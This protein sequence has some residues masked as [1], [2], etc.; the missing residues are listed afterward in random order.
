MD[1][2]RNKILQYRRLKRSIVGKRNPTVGSLVPNW[3]QDWW[4]QSGNTGAPP[5]HPDL[6][7]VKIGS[8]IYDSEQIVDRVLYANAD[9]AIKRWP[10]RTAPTVYV[11]KKGQAVGRV[12]SFVGGPGSTRYPYLFWMFKD[13]GNRIYYVEHCDFCFSEDELKQ[14]G[15]VNLETQ[16][17]QGQESEDFFG[18]L[19]SG[20]KQVQSLLII[21]GLVYVGSK[22][23]GSEVDKNKK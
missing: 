18:K 12:Y 9:L 7:K 23:I 4:T 1:V 5:V 2:N 16:M 13:S 8:K 14:Q 6:P 22:V 20:L 21:A 10:E 11:V 17:Q 3:V 19:G 15:S